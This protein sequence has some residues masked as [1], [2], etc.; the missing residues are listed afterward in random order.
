M[1]VSKEV[2]AD[3][4]AADPTKA[5][6]DNQAS[7]EASATGVKYE[8]NTEEVEMEEDAAVAKKDEHASKD[9]PQQP[10]GQGLDEQL[11]ELIEDND[12]MTGSVVVGEKANCE[13]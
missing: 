13:I 4:G 12:S 5:E 6:G 1:G 8:Q 2:K 9:D 11:L 10:V 7:Q 3:F